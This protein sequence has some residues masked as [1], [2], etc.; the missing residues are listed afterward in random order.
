[1]RR[2]DDWERGRVSAATE[3]TAETAV[4]VAD[5]VRI[6][7][8][9]DAPLGVRLALL[10][11]ALRR[12]LPAYSDEIDRMVQRLQ[13]GGFGAGAPQ[14]GAVMAPFVLPDDQGRLVA[15]AGLLSA[16]PVAVVFLRGHWCPYCQISLKALARAQARIASEGLRIVAITPERQPFNAA[17]KAQADAGFPILT[18]LDNG[19]AL[20]LNLVFWLGDELPARLRVGSGRDV[21]QAQ[22]NDAWF[23]PIP[24]TF[25][26]GADGVIKARF[27]DPDYRKRMD[28]DDMIAALRSVR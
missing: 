23:F 25:V 18:D 14:P 6:C 20:S 2:W 5:A 12:L 19:Y 22:G 11:R 21:E 8:D 13:E 24:A 10:T 1:M 28:L 16:G 17:F 3:E 9:M 7:R 26:V 15:L 27:V 4:T